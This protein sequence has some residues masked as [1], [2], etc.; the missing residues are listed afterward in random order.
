WRAKVGQASRLPWSLDILNPPRSHFSL[1]FPD[2]LSHTL[3]ELTEFESNVRSRKTA[4][5]RQ[6]TGFCRHG[7]GLDQY[8]GQKTCPGRGIL[9]PEQQSG[10]QSEG[11]SPQLLVSFNPAAARVWREAAVAR[12]PPRVQNGSSSRRPPAL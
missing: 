5:L 1:P 9:N 2:T 8:L 6:S 12:P 4:R 7:S 3:S 11:Q 10:R